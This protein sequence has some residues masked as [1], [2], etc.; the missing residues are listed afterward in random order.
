VS[1]L[2]WGYSGKSYENFSSIP[3]EEG[4]VYE[5]RITEISGHGDGIAK[6]QGFV[7]FIPNTRKGDLVK[8]KVTE[9][10]SNYAVGKTL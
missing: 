1:K 5:S 6:I 10:K 2:N 3:V 9:V 7:V 4:N 8:F